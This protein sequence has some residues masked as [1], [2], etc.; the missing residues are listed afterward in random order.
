MMLRP[1]CCGNCFGDF[2]IHRD[3]RI[4]AD[5]STNSTPRASVLEDVRG[6]VAFRG[7]PRHVQL[8]HLLW[9][10][11]DAKFTSFAVPITDFNPTSCRHLFSFSKPGFSILIL[12]VWDHIAQMDGQDPAHVERV[13]KKSSFMTSGI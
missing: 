12:L 10:C 5:E 9:T 7:K 4:R 8:H 3:C 6:V 13:L 1:S 11:A 2:T